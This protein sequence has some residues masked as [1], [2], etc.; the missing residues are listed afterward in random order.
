M[1]LLKDDEIAQLLQSNPTFIHG[2]PPSTVDYEPIRPASLNL[3]VG[4]I[5]LPQKKGDELGSTD[6]PLTRHALKP[7]QIV[8]ITSLEELRMPS[9][10]AGLGFPPPNVSSFGCFMTN[11]GHIDPGY[12]GRLRFTLVN[13]GNTDFIIS[14]G[15]PIFVMM[16][17]ELSSNVTRDWHQRRGNAAGHR[18]TE[19]DLARLPVDF[20]DVDKRAE[21]RARDVSVKLINDAEIEL[22]SVD[23]KVKWWG[24]LYTLIVTATVAIVQFFGPMAPRT[25]VDTLQKEINTLA[26]DLVGLR[27]E[28]KVQKTAEAIEL[29]RKRLETLET[30]S[31]KKP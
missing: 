3:H 14:K 16:L 29:F 11:A 1:K 13:L 2:L 5:L 8:V 10:L 17:V 28:L 7:G 31:Q 12:H 24:G 20:L 6:A 15:D 4:D 27:G 30:M 23:Q 9:N 18:L 21:E 19:R 22:K 26:S 25:A